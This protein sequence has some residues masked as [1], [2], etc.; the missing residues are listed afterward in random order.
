MAAI[1][2]LCQ[3]GIV[4]YQGRIG[5]IGAQTEVVAQYLKSLVDNTISLRERSDRQ[6]SGEVR[7]VGIVVRDIQGNAL[8]VVISGQNVD[9]Y[10]Y[11]ETTQLA[12]NRGIVAGLNIKTQLGIPVFLQHNRLTGNVFDNLPPKGAFVCRIARLPL[13]PSVYLLGYSVMP[14]DG[15]SGEYFDLIED[16]AELT[17]VAGDFFGSGEVPPISHG[18]CLVD[19][20][21]RLVD[22]SCS[23][24]PEHYKTCSDG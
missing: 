17:V 6:G 2:N 14:N 24:L 16:A 13:P 5:H 12:S 3:R 9:I 19:G 8:D 18:V 7:I 10:F 20:E 21:W 22:S 11:Y 15:R 23:G 1:A 4:L